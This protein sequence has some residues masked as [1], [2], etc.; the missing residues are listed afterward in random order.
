MP[1]IRDTGRCVSM[2]ILVRQDNLRKGWKYYD[3]M[4]KERKV[5]RIYE[6]GKCTV[7]YPSFL[8]YNLFLDRDDDLDSRVNNLNNFYY[9][10][11]SR[12]L[13]LDRKYAKE[14]MAAIGAN[15]AV[16]DR[17]RAMIAISYHG[18]SLTDVYWI[19][20]AGEK[21]SFD[22]ISLYSH[23]LSDAFVNVSLR[24]SS[25]T[26]Q[27]AELVLS[28]NAAGDIS[29][30]G[31]APKAWIRENSRICLMKDGEESEVNAELLASKIVDCFNVAH[32]SYREDF[33]EGTRVSKCELIT[34]V[35]RSIVSF[36]YIVVYCANN[37]LDRMKYALKKD[38][39]AYYMMNIVDYL[40]G[41]TDRHWGNWGFYVDNCNNKITGLYPLMDFNKAFGSYGT[42]DGSVCQTSDRRMTQREA[43][44]EAVRAVGLNQIREIDETWFDDEK[45]KDM[46]F[47]RLN[48]LRQTAK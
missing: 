8:P 33:F 12:V 25:I 47:A 39:Y 26:L 34:S 37:S 4:H 19:R 29:V 46:F 31:V 45:T 7:N 38:R 20:G 1:V 24:G 18:L 32:V 2:S 10:C 40:I 42:L 22:A 27:N 23:S 3:I 5:A 11:S 48:C 15:Q 43:A 28:R 41:N 9:W 36:E 44:I 17:D 30:Q 14:I 35:E 13:T 21:T 6:N 16:T